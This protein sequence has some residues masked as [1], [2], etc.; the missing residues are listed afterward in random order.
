MELIDKNGLKNHIKSYRNTVCD[1]CG[2]DWLGCKDECPLLKFLD[3]NI[4]EIIDTQMVVESK[5]DT[6]NAES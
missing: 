1:Y 4:N 2:R 6:D 5:E 3:E